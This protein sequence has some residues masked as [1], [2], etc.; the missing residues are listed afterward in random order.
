MAALAAFD[1]RCGDPTKLGA[2]LNLHRL[3]KGISLSQAAAATVYIHK[4]SVMRLVTGQAAL[5]KT[6]NM[7]LWRS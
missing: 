1:R 3:P 2:G 6:E 7:H 4:I 5:D